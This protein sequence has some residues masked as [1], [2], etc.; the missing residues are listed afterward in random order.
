M[1][2][3]NGLISLVGI[4]YFWVNEK[5][6]DKLIFL[7]VSFAA[8]N[9]LSGAFFHLMVHSFE[10]LDVELAFGLLIVGFSSF[11]FDS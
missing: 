11:R 5:Y 9:L 2:F 10:H 6:L 1:T 3:I 4:F 7:M 8:G